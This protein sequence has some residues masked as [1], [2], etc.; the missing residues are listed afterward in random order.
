MNVVTQGRKRAVV[1]A[2]VHLIFWLLVLGAIARKG[3]SARHGFIAAGIAMF[4]AALIQYRAVLAYRRAARSEQSRRD[5]RE[6]AA[7]RNSRR[8]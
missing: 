4:V 5:S 6:V 2:T 7:L 8:R 3:A 1:I